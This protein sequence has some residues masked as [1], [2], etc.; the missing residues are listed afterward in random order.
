MRPLTVVLITL[1]IWGLVFAG[2]LDGFRFLRDGFHVP[3]RGEILGI[4]LDLLFLTLGMLLVFTGGLILYG[5][6]FTAPETAFLLSTPLPD[7]QVFAHK[8]QGA[9]R[10]QRLGVPAAGRAAPDR[11]RHRLR[12]RRGT[13]TPCCRSF[14]SVSSCCRPR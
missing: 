9:D 7:D 4:L 3:L 5:S 10:H 11:L 12:A 8:F 6:L 13:S 1:L 2:S 14:F